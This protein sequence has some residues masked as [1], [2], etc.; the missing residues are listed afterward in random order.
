MA[1]TYLK[2]ADNAETT[3]NGN[4]TDVADSIVVTSV[5]TLP[6]TFPYL[7]TIW[8][9]AIY[10]DPSDDPSME[11]VLVGGATAN[12]LTSV[13][14]GYG[15]T[16]GVAHVDTNRIALLITRE[17][18]TD[19]TYGVEPIMDAHMDAD[20]GEHGVGSDYVTKTSKSSQIGEFTATVVVGRGGAVDYICDG[21]ADDVQIQAAIDY[22]IS[23][24]GGIILLRSGI[25]NLATY[26]SLSSSVQLTII[27][28]SI[29]DTEITFDDVNV[30][31][32][33]LTDNATIHCEN[34]K[35]TGTNTTNGEGMVISESSK[36]INLIFINCI[37][38]TLVIPVLINNHSG[39]DYIELG[40]IVF[41]NCLF[42]DCAR[43]EADI[44]RWSPSAIQSILYFSG[45][46]GNDNKLSIKNNMFSKTS[47]TQRALLSAIYI[48]GNG[49]SG[50]GD[51][52]S[53]AIVD[54]NI[55][56]NTVEGTT[57]D[58][59][60]ISD[61]RN[62]TVINN[63]I[64]NSGRFGL[65]IL[66]GYKNIVTDNNISNCVL[67]GFRL[68]QN[69]Y[70]VWSNNTSYNI[71]SG[72]SDYG[73]LLNS[74]NNNIFSNN[75]V[76]CSGNAFY[77]GKG[78][79][80]GVLYASYGNY[81]INNRLT[82]GTGIVYEDATEPLNTIRSP[83]SWPTISSGSGAPSSTPA[84]IGDIYIDTST[85]AMYYAKGIA[86]SADWIAS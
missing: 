39:E 18:F 67:R 85:P 9:E 12:T 10:P 75:I 22:V 21:V 1:G 55:S 38:D 73:V 19:A 3:L 83:D 42:D 74:C 8:D 66:R 5:S 11:Q 76:D 69:S 40:D 44:Y 51:D 72:L 13:T 86:S 46:K 57:H 43:S 14:R 16:S 60:Y 49:N 52:D 50:T 27:G 79:G 61:S 37:F 41:E 68:E 56:N 70:C 84:K 71:N 64:E 78:T 47:S 35:F 53:T 33:S 32:S 7:L 6:S 2:L 29:N 26:L 62:L 80:T 23:D 81:V 20:T 54:G 63:T 82:N 4:I 15:G 45:K 30:F 77:V 24:G 59:I 36:T 58:P 34:I 17:V 28:E 65:S 25:Y 48:I 31:S